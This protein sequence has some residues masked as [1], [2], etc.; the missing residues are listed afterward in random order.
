MASPLASITLGFTEDHVENNVVVS[1]N[2]ARV[3]LIPPFIQYIPYLRSYPSVS[4]IA[5]VSSEAFDSLSNPC[6]CD[7]NSDDSMLR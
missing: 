3:I 7:V 2:V 6:V 1:T 5:L 4:T